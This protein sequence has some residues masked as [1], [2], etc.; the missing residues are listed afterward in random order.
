M[1]MGA[2]HLMTRGDDFQAERPF[3]VVDYNKSGLLIFF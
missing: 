2:I 1:A 3:I